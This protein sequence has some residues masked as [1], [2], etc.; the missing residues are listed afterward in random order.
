[1][2][3]SSIKEDNMRLEW[4]QISCSG[5]INAV[6]SQLETGNN[7]KTKSSQ[8]TCVFLL[9]EKHTMRPDVC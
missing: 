4:M 9:S 8:C 6:S 5:E 2:K 3:P 7:H 1:M